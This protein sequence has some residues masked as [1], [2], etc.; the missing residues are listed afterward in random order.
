VY[1]SSLTAVLNAAG[2][3]FCQQLVQ[4]LSSAASKASQQLVSVLAYAGVCW[5]MLSYAGV[6]WRML[7]YA[8]VC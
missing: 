1:I 3:F 5:R 2:G 7:A 4:H 8:D 6:C